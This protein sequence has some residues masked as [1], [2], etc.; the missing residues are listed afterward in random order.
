MDSGALKPE[1]R[2]DIVEIKN[3]LIKQIRHFRSLRDATV[4]SGQNAIFVAQEFF[5]RIKV[6]LLWKV[7][8][9]IFLCQGGNTT[10]VGKL[11]ELWTVSCKLYGCFKELL[12]AMSGKVTLEFLADRF[13]SF[14]STTEVEGGGETANGLNTGDKECR[15]EGEHCSLCK[16]RNCDI[17]R[18][19]LECFTV[20]CLSIA[21]NVIG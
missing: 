16:F 5:A 11:R 2:T 6:V 10:T 18:T 8:Q 4:S 3:H 19:K 14:F 12:L 13:F 20:F 1:V 7:R 9:Q 15:K 17:I 21:F